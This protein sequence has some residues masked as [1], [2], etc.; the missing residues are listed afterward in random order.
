MKTGGPCIV[1]GP[2][3]DDR[4]RRWSQ[5]DGAGGGV[6]LRPFS[7]GREVEPSAA[8]AVLLGPLGRRFF[9]FGDEDRTDW[10]MGAGGR[11]GGWA[12]AG[13]DTVRFVFGGGG[14][15]GGGEVDRFG[16]AGE[17]VGDSEQR[18]GG[19]NAGGP[20][21]V[22]DCLPGL[23]WADERA[24]R[25]PHA[26]DDGGGGAT[27]AGAGIGIG[28][29]GRVV[30]SFGGSAVDTGPLSTDTGGAL[31]DE[32]AVVGVGAWKGKVGM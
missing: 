5:G 22:E 29:G 23:D 4:A 12:L 10:E 30:S 2:D 31:N 1:V 25:L 21:M 32:T 15:G 9:H 3:A 20:N 19:R 24:S 7:T 27:G 17:G 14:G 28:G 18:A 8:F 26:A 6:E 16:R 11:R 13:L